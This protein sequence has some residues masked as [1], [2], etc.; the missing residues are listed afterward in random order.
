[1]NLWWIFSININSSPILSELAEHMCLVNAIHKLNWVQRILRNYFKR[2]MKERRD[3]HT[4]KK[5]NETTDKKWCAP[6][7]LS[8]SLS[9]NLHAYHHRALTHAKHMEFKQFPFS[10]RQPAE[11]INS[12][13]H[14]S[15][16]NAFLILFSILFSLYLYLNVCMCTFARCERVYRILSQYREPKPWI[17]QQSQQY[18]PTRRYSNWGKHTTYGL[19]ALHF[20]CVYYLYCVSIVYICMHTG[21]TAKVYG[22]RFQNKNKKKTQQHTFTRSLSH[23][24]C[25]LHYT[26]IVFGV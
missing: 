18:K 19:H 25:I 9:G 23:S 20:A 3:I 7:W 17:D 24:L 22:N 8:D 21:S 5:N 6:D 10:T 2:D 15:C 13:D 26:L 1:M 14:C 4:K 11:H 16:E 12:S